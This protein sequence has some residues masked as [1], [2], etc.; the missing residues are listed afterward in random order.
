MG[1]NESFPPPP[2]PFGV[3]ATTCR[4]AADAAR[5]SE[6]VAQCHLLRDIFHGPRPPVFIRQAWLNWNSRTAVRLAQVI[7]DECRFGDLPILADA[8]LDAG[9]TEAGLLGHLRDPGPHF[10]GC[11][12]VDALLLK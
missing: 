10:K 5:R 3:R 8:L 6:N 4:E 1:Y 2:D 11:W 7:Y 9:C 12:A